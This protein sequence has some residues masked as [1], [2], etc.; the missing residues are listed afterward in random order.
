[1]AAVLPGNAIRLLAISYS[2][3]PLAQENGQLL[4]HRHLDENE[5][6]ADSNEVSAKRPGTGC[7]I[8]IGQQDVNCQFR[9][10][11]YI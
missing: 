11:G 2:T 7:S 4:H 9:S 10:A 8:A 1:M 5:T 6:K 3:A